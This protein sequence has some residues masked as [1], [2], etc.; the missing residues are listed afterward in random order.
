MLTAD[1]VCR[2]VGAGRACTHDRSLPGES[3]QRLLVRANSVRTGEV[4]AKAAF[5]PIA[6]KD[7]S[8]LR[9]PDNEK[10]ITISRDFMVSEL[11][12]LMKPNDVNSG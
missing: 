7:R 3:A 4:K 1:R 8:N 12:G 11:S 6:R 10:I 2:G 9:G 5:T